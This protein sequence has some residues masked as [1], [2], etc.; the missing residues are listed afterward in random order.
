[1]LVA[2]L[3]VLAVV[4]DQCDAAAASG[5]RNMEANQGWLA[6]VRVA[7]AVLAWSMLPLL[8][9]EIKP[10]RPRAVKVVTESGSNAAVTTDSVARRLAW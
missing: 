4:Q 5:L 3:Q 6:L 9:Q 2:L 10:R 1:M 7:L 8:W